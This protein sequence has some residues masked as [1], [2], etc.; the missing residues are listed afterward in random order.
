MRARLIVLGCAVNQGVGTAIRLYQEAI[1]VSADG[2]I[3]PQTLTVAY[4]NNADET[5]AKFLAL[6]AMRYAHN[7][8]FARYGNGWM[9]RL[10]DV[11]Q[12]AAANV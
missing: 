11:S 1:G 12:R 4:Q 7:S 3:G 2:L 9:K 8:N 10:F 6:R 5:Y